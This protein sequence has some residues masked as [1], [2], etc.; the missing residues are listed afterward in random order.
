M[1][2]YEFD[3]SVDFTFLFKGQM[4]STKVFIF[5]RLEV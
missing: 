5:Q 3:V 1:G 2:E 4:K